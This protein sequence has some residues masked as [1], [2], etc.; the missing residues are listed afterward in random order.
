MIGQPKEIIASNVVHL[1]CM[2]FSHSENTLSHLD[3]KSMT[4]N[5]I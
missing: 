4:E 5:L 3:I 1:L 2:I